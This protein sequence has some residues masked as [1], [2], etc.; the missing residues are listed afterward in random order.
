MVQGM[1]TTLFSFQSALKLHSRLI[2]IRLSPQNPGLEL[3]QQI[4][5][6]SFV[7]SLSW[8]GEPQPKISFLG[9]HGL[10]VMTHPP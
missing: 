3:P 4:I 7:L 1:I 9:P 5:G 6:L 2:S 8:P 10:V